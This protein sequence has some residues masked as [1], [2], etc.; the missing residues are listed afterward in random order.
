MYPELSWEVPKWNS[1]QSLC[2]FVQSQWVSI[3]N[4]SCTERN[5]WL[6]LCKDILTSFKDTHKFMAGRGSKF[7]LE[8]QPNCS[9]HH[10]HFRK[11]SIAI[12]ELLHVVVPIQIYYSVHYSKDTYSIVYIVHTW[13]YQIWFFFFFCFPLNWWCNLG[14]KSLRD[15]F[16]Y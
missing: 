10:S 11:F 6:V 3:K 8:G 13:F 4:C 9:A 15:K 7:G 12:I 1:K 2:L 5:H 16:G 14:A